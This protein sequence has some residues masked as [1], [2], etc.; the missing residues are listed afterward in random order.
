[1]DTA[2]VVDTAAADTP[3]PAEAGLTEILFRKYIRIEVDD[4]FAAA[5]GLFLAVNSPS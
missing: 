5:R 1:V 3:P 2:A 4:F